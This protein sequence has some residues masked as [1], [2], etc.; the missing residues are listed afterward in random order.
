MKKEFSVLIVDDDE[1]ICK[2][3]NLWIASFGYWGDVANNG[4][5]ALEKLESGKYDIV[6]S[7]FLMPEMGG[8]ELLKSIKNIDPH[9]DVIIITGHTDRT[10]YCDVIHAGASDF[11][12][13]PFEKAEM[14]AKLSRVVRERRLIN[15]LEVRSYQDS[16]TH[17]NNRR[18][19]D[20]KFQEEILRSRRQGFQTYLAL[21]DIDNFKDCNDR[22][23]HPFGDQILCQVGKVLLEGTRQNVDFSF[24]LGGDEFATIITQTSLGQAK[25]ILGRIMQA[26]SENNQAHTS[27]SVG[28]V[29]CSG[30]EGPNEEAV[31]ASV[32]QRA[33]DALY[34]AKAE[35]KGRLV[36][37]LNGD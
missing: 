11:L 12:V 18:Y 32:F 30:K 1:S 36:V 22:F 24:R 9:I 10:N 33:D 3:L 14:E 13:K 31:A 28:L 4:I 16:L 23:G 5:Q 34:R 15:K 27:L 6:V 20:I 25:S 17:L 19:F 8:L 35:G 7:D 29:D 37:V 21:L 2:I 26:F